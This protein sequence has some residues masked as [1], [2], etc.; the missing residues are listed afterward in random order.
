[1]TR[2]KPLL[3]SIVMVFSLIL[4]PNSIAS[5]SS[6]GDPGESWI[7]PN[8]AALGENI[9][10]FA[11]STG[12]QPSDLITNSFQPHKLVNPVCLS[13]TEDKCKNGYH[14]QAI[15]PQ[16]LTNED[17]NCIADFG[18]IDSNQNRI[19]AKFQR[20]FPH[21][22]QNQFVGSP[23][24]GV[25]DGVAGSLYQLSEAPFEGGNTYFVR[26]KVNGGGNSV[27]S[28]ID[29]FEA[30]ISA[31]NYKDVNFSP[32]P[33]PNGT[34]YT[35]QDAGMT[36]NHFLLDGID[37]YEWGR[38]APGF[39]GVADCIATSVKESKCLQRYSFP[40][41]KKY[42]LQIRMSMMPSGW[43]HG[44]IT[45]PNISISLEGSRTIFSIE[46]NPISTPIVYKMYKWVEMPPLLQS[47]YDTKTACFINGPEIKAN[48]QNACYGGRSAGNIDPLKR[49]IINAPDAWSVAGMQQLKLILPYVNDQATAMSSDWSI[50]TITGN[51]MS[52]AN[53]CFS[54]A[55]R[56][57]GIISTNATQY[58]AGP[59]TFDPVEQTLNYQVGAPHF[60]NK[61]VEF[62]GSYDLVIR[63]DVAR[64]IYGFSN[65]PVKA[66][67]SIVAPDGTSKVATTSLIEK[68]G[69]M[70][71]SANGFT[72]S[73]PTVQVKLTQEA[74]VATP[75]PTPVLTPT[76]SP[77]P[78][79]SA[80]SAAPVTP[81]ET[82][83]TIKPAS[84]KKS[85]IIC[86]KGTVTK[87]VSAIKPTCPRGYKKK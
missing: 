31:V 3:I 79:A 32:Q 36:Y 67:I 70:N 74:P 23:A 47:Q 48:P 65:A 26:V 10:W 85:T 34:F 24:I 38:S 8:D 28:R 42:F 56:I 7:P 63:S 19:S 27:S 22:A 71:F 12:E 43:M 46:A 55:S 37:N 13:I 25:P 41:E 54:D 84:S 73:S 76:P 30:R 80:P 50:R 82:A 16:C 81:Q 86:Y 61:K 57:T 6:V 83:H 45:N 4:L 53:K 75:T 58:S 33:L 29:R 49:N 62:S 14:Y 15:L 20:Y 51:E 2:I 44:R 18:I 5:I 78:E 60:T 77:T 17:I 87:K 21:R 64:C 40:A 35:P 52:G 68:D 11:D 9:F 69:W 72:F 59:P 1:M 66:T 39:T